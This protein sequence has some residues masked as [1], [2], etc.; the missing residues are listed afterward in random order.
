MELYEETAEIA[1]PQPRA[2]EAI[3]GVT[4]V[5]TVD[6]SRCAGCQECVVRCPVGALGIDPVSWTATT[7]NAAC[8]GCRQC[9]R[10]CPYAAIAV[11]GP[12]LV[13]K[14]MPR[15]HSEVEH[16]AFSTATTRPGLSDLAAAQAEAERCLRCPDPTCVLGCP[17]HNDIP[18]FIAAVREGHVDRARDIL[19]ATTVFPDICSRVCD[20][21]TQCEGACSWRLAGEQPVS[22]GLLERF[23]AD[24]SPCAPPSASPQNV[25]APVLSV[26]I[27]GS[28]PAGLAAAW[29]LRKAGARVVMYERE[30]A[31]LGVLRWG[32]PEFTL[33]DRVARRPVDQLLAS[34]VELSVGADVGRTVA[35]KDLA[36]RH[37]AVIL[38]HGA[39]RPLPAR[40]AGANLP[41]VEDAT[42]F[43]TRAR[44]SLA[45]HM[46]LE[47]PALD[48]LLL[49]L[50][51]GNTAM[52]VARTALRLGVEHVLCV[53]WM[54]ERFAKVRPDEVA[55]ARAEGVEVRFLTSLD[56]LAEDAHGQRTAKLVRTVQTSS[57][58]RPKILQ[59]WSESLPVGHV[60]VAMGYGVESYAAQETGARLS[61]RVPDVTR[62]I[63]PRR[64]MASG[65]LSAAGPVPRLVLEREFQHQSALTPVA[66]R[67]W[68]IGDAL[69]GPATVVAAMAQGLAVSREILS[70][71]RGALDWRLGT[72]GWPEAQ[73]PVTS[74]PSPKAERLGLVK[75]GGGVLALGLVSCVTVVGLPLGIPFLFIGGLLMGLGVLFEWVGRGINQ[76]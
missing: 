30:A 6:P 59:S 35:L 1:F 61:R 12:V 40:V 75:A 8:V 38:A 34:G 10:T 7:I 49:V 46:T 76:L 45:Q 4:P 68:A 58:A 39:S 13:S 74:A 44:R 51:A 2:D 17:A 48:S 55:E 22:I 62:T 54:D 21:S 3:R 56:A 14:P 29:E 50:G 33:P 36:S 67:V 72:R 19:S 52:D 65:L 9:V 28:G 64:L 23:V 18:G 5:V 57:R 73:A 42:S 20:Q 47:E 41:W 43:L 16:L 60:V 26:G 53:D 71:D 24:H 70:T 66:P 69:T 25:H 27:V 32:I 63:A 31:P 11:E 15:P 37:D